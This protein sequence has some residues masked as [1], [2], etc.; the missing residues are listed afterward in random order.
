MDSLELYG[1][2]LYGSVHRVRK[3]L[4]NGVTC[5]VDVDRSNIPMMEVC[6]EYQ[7]PGNYQ[8]ECRLG[9]CIVCKRQAVREL[10]EMDSSTFENMIQWLPREMMEDIIRGC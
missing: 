7:V 10:W 8:L 3:L 4:E 2:V 6:H 1:A 9:I 5:Y